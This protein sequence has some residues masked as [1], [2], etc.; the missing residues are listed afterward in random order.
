[1]VLV[2]AN[3][4]FVLGSLTKFNPLSFERLYN[5]LKLCDIQV[6]TQGDLYK[7]LHKLIEEKKVET[8]DGMYRRTY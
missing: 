6:K 7:T 1:M 4:A 5:T 3:E 8:V 2:G